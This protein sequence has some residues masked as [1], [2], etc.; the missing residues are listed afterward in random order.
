MAQSYAIIL[1]S[2]PKNRT[3]ARSKRGSRQDHRF[4][5]QRIRQWRMKY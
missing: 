1:Q 3:F 2:S 5:N 4:T